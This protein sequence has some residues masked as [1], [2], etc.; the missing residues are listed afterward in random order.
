MSLSER[1][2]QLCRGGTREAGQIVLEHGLQALAQ[3]CPGGKAGWLTSPDSQVSL[4]C[5]VGAG[6]GATNSPPR[7]RGSVVEAAV[8]P[9]SHRPLASPGPALQAC[10]PPGILCPFCPVHLSR[11]SW[12]S[13]LLH[14]PAQSRTLAAYLWTKH[15]SFP[16]LIQRWTDAWVGSTSWKILGAVL[17]SR[18]SVCSSG[19]SVVGRVLTPASAGSRPS[20]GHWPGPQRVKTSA[21]ALFHV[22]VV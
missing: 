19:S 7:S 18:Q 14:G 12:L 8:Q 22:S 1:R 4:D 16:L 15:P 20:H 6:M 11:P 5:M 3:G 10:P 2:H 9:L 21:G 13:C 17:A